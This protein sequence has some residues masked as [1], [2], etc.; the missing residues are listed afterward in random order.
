MGYRGNGHLK[1]VFK[2]LDNTVPIVHL[3]NLRDFFRIGAAILNRY[4]SP[5]SMEGANAELAREL[6]AKSRQPN[7]LQVFVEMEQ[8]HRRSAQ[9][10]I[11]LNSIKSMTFHY[12]L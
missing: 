8:L 2:F 9:R 7:V 1:S 6:L 5:I 12:W 4:H 3:S 10:W 11:K